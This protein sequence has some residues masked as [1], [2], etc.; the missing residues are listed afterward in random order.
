[1]D[2]TAIALCDFKGQIA[3]HDLSRFK[4]IFDDQL[5]LGFLNGKKFDVS[6]ALGCLNDYVY[7]RTTK[8]QTWTKTNLLPSVV[9]FPLGKR[10]NIL[11]N[12]DVKGN[13]VVID[14]GNLW[15]TTSTT[16]DEILTEMLF[17][18]DELIRTY[19]VDSESNEV[20]LIC[21]GEG[22]SIRHSLIRTPSRV[23]K[24]MDLLLKSVPIRP[25]GIHL[26]NAGPII[27]FLSRIA[28]GFLPEKIRQRSV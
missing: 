1:M 9:T 19:L 15:H 20:T 24:M 5:L 11:K 18:A 12:K 16:Y 7:V 2:P 8:H 3:K 17:V 22:L 26:I 14:S 4:C 28:T 25:A 10:F 21:D 13:L 27:S 6:S 23:M